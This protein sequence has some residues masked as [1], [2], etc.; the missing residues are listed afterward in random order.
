ML[1]RIFGFKIHSILHVLGVS[2]LAFGLPFNKVLMSIG[3]IW[4]V[5]NL[6]LEGDF[7]HYGVNIRKNTAFLWLLLF[8]A[9]HL[10]GLIWTSD[11]SYAMHDIKIKLPLLAVPLALVARPINERSKVNLVL[12]ALLASLVMTSLLNFGYYNQWFG[13]K[14]YTN[15]RQ[16]SL[17]GSHIRYGIIIALG[18]GICL[19]FIDFKKKMILNLLWLVL[20][21]W[22]SVYT[23]YSQILSGAIS[24]I[25][26]LLAFLISKLYY[27]NKGFAYSLLSVFVALL[28][29]LVMY[30][31]PSKINKVDVAS[32]PVKTKEG[33]LY[34][35][36]L[37]DFNTEG[38]EYIYISVCEVEIEREWNKRSQL[39]YGGYDK[40]GQIVKC[41]IIR[42]LSSKNLS[43]DAEGVKSLSKEE[44]VNIENGIAS[45]H[46][47]QSGLFARLYEVKH[48][49]NNATNP[50]GHSLLQR[51]EYWKIGLRIIEKNWLIGVGTGDVQAVFDRQ[52]ELDNS[53]L[54]P[55]LR[56]RAHNMYLTIFI[57]FG[58][59]GLIV[60]LSF[61]RS[62]FIEN[63][64][65]RELIAIMFICISCVTFLIEDTIET[66]MGVSLVALFVGLYL[67]KLEREG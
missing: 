10:I 4:G 35:N 60:F 53:V 65:N 3:A 5:S 61:I 36:H 67:P 34:V 39:E 63:F 48:Q 66:Q 44:I 7:K 50:N 30:F 49:I 42:Y 18:A 13:F 51:L 15:I 56:L 28:A 46:L 8:C 47:L 33:N 57:T 23:F 55:K 54:I 11:F 22:F 26:V 29:G 17:F 6:I 64:K 21:S 9:L 24:M 37:D 52:Y 2:I 1:D 20:F 62:Y 41:S 38:D 32:L 59:A 19:T 25:V 43:K 31:L 16:M 12:Y 14:S 45:V 58:I 40:H 27:F